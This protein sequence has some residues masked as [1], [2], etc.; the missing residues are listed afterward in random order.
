VQVDTGGYGVIW[1]DDIDLSR[2]ELYNNGTILDA[3][4]QDGS[5]DRQ[6]TSLHGRVN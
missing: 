5:L 2:N 4:F 6:I 3:S 1:N